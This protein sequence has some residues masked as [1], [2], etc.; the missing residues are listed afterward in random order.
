MQREKI[1]NEYY[2][3]G[4]CAGTTNALI[5]TTFRLAIVHQILLMANQAY[6]PIFPSHYQLQK[7]EE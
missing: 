5:L 2:T 3:R 6:P 1:M 7:T 4:C